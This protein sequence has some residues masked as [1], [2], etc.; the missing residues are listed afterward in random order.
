MKLLRRRGAGEDSRRLFFVTDLHGSSTAF[1]K[2]L[3]AAR[4]YKVDSLICGGD[5]AGKRLY[6]IVDGG[7]GSYMCTV[8]GR[9]ERFDGEE[10]LARAQRLI[11]EAGAYHAT[12]APEAAAALET[13]AEQLDTLFLEKVR[14]RLQQWLKLADERLQET[15]AALYVTGGNDDS[16]EMLA[17]LREL[18]SP[19]VVLC[20]G[21]TV[22]IA[23]F[24]M[25]SLG[26]SNETPWKT[27]RETT[28]ERLAELIEQ[29]VADVGDFE[30]AIF[31]FHVP[32]KNST[33][34]TCPA[35]DTSTFP[36]KPIMRGSEQIFIGAGSSAVDEAIRRY[37]PLLSLHGHI[38][39]SPGVVKLG[40]TTAINPG[41]EYQH[42]ALQGAIVT[43]EDG[44]VAGYQLT[45]G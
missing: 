36:P 38:H 44:A 43:L 2:L 16:E 28:E 32:P 23:G 6:P 4:V 24:P 5:L 11:E 41:S 8:H 3:N 37:Q 29:A 25:A 39:E 19:R 13:D 17:P 31:N 34:D 9:E 12:L 14:E 7:D 45:R 20:E 27:P 35:L 1:R 10:G 18:E 42:G 30:R 22:E 26:W 40:R 21:R 33:L 15:G